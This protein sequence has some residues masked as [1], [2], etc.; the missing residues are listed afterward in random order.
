MVNI[1]QIHENVRLKAFTN[2]LFE[3]GDAS[4]EYT[5]ASGEYFVKNILTETVPS[6]LHGNGLSKP[7]LNNFGSY[8]AGAFKHKEC[9]LCTENPLLFEVSL[10]FLQEILM[11]ESRLLVFISG[12]N[13]NAKYHRR[14]IHHKSHSLHGRIFPISCGFRLSK[15]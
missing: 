10:I 7:L 1:L 15:R 4:V 9:Q 6:L 14:Y 3:T 2:F 11:T 12:S 5:D 13:T 8:I